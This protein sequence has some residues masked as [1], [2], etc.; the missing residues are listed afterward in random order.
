METRLGT[1]D[2]FFIVVRMHC[3]RAR[4]AEPIVIDVWPGNAAKMMPMRSARR[5]GSIP[6]W[7]QV[8][9]MGDQRHPSDAHDLSAS[10]DKDNGAAVLI[11]PGGGYHALMWDLEGREVAAGSTR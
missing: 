11:C 6:A 10:H 4:A 9:E 7:G 3:F 2:C 1:S 8:A 5:S